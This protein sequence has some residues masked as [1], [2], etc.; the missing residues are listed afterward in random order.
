MGPVGWSGGGAAH[1]GGAGGDHPAWGRGGE[2]GP[3]LGDLAAAA[4][5]VTSEAR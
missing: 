3:G 4:A 5:A 1:R 2:G